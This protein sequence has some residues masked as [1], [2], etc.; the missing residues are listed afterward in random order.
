MNSSTAH[1][2]ALVSTLIRHNVRYVV[3]CPGS[4]NA[5]LTYALAQAEAAG[6]IHLRVAI[7]ERSAAFIALG[8]ARGIAVVAGDEQWASAH[9]NVRPLAAV[10]TT[11]GSAVANLHPAVAEADAAGIPLLVISADRPHEAVGTGANQTS[12]QPGMM[13][14]AMRYIADIPAGLAGDHPGGEQQLIGHVTRA[15][16]AACGDFTHDPGPAQINM[17]LRP[18]LVPADEPWDLE[19]LRAQAGSAIPSTS[20]PAGLLLGDSLVS[21]HTL[22]TSSSY[23]GQGAHLG[24]SATHG[25]QM[26]LPGHDVTRGLVLIAEGASADAAHAALA[27]AQRR[28]W[29]V[30]A[31]PTSGARVPGCLTAYSSVLATDLALDIEAVVVCGH[32][33]LSRPVTALL[34]R[35]DIPITVVAPHARWWDESGCAACVIS[36]EQFITQV[37]N[38][39]WG[40]QT[41]SRDER[42][43][44]EQCTSRTVEE[45]PWQQ[46]WRYACEHAEHTIDE[47]WV[48]HSASVQADAEGSAVSARQVALVVWAQ[49]E[50]LILVVGSS[51]AIRYLDQSAPGRAH[52]GRVI[53]NR[54]LAGIDGTISTAMGVAW[55]SGRSVRVLC[56]DLTAVHDVMAFNMG[57]KEDDLPVHVVVIDD[58]GGAI[59]AGLEYGKRCAQYPNERDFYERFFA[60]P[61]RAV[62]EEIVKACGAQGERLVSLDAL[63]ESL[64]AP[65]FGTKVSV[66]DCSHS[67]TIQKTPRKA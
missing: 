43:V 28:G 38:T 63:R 18:P 25:G 7:D 46:Q 42:E 55:G 29:P 67:A 54:G 51:M 58:C 36:E 35:T 24:A 19:V 21:S 64:Q 22:C 66:V 9:E 53:A 41:P 65:V 48:A 16:A 6:L 62:L 34:S 45:S 26:T 5:P 30:C 10:V 39:Q 15:I 23:G 11:S 3:C 32:P 60:T 57:L 31:E 8:V 40:N 56:G 14:S 44:G 20:A 4:R 17:R 13:R 37:N 50:N 27:F 12:D 33:T 52:A 61:Q 2:R 47:G 1:A 59:F 49:S